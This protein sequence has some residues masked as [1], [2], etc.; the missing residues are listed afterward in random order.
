MTVVAYVVNCTNECS[1]IG[2]SIVPRTA[3]ARRPSWMTSS[4]IFRKGLNISVI[5]HGERLLR[6]WIGI[7]NFWTMGLFKQARWITIVSKH[8]PL[9]VSI[10]SGQYLL[11]AGSPH[12]GLFSKNNPSSIGLHRWIETTKSI[13]IVSKRNPL[14]ISIMSG[15]YLFNKGSPHNVQRLVIWWIQ[16]LP[17]RDQDSITLFLSTT[18]FWP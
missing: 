2:V 10:M 12:N 3:H 18:Q 17:E 14:K 9:K 6:Q 4:T 7:Y 16:Y 13:T 11:S 15:Q 8:N 5:V 1:S